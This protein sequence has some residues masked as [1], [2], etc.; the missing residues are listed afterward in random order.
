MKFLADIQTSILFVRALRLLGWDIARA[1]DHNQDAKA[2]ESVLHVATSL[3]RVLIT[4]DYFRP[5]TRVRVAT[6][7]R[8]YGGRVIRIGGGPDQATERAIGKLLFHHPDWH[9]WLE[10]NE[11]KV[12]IRDITQK[13]T[14]RSRSD[15]HAEIRHVDG[16]QFEPYLDHKKELRKR[17]L[18]RKP[19][20]R[21]I[22][23]E[24]KHLEDA[25]G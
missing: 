11:G 20:K 6:E 15:I 8:D 23:P 25:H 17:P 4:F 22:A 12:E 10:A 19:R 24:Q 13:L 18:N 2:D 16:D 5:P 7:L 14:L 3:N 21:K 9:P 1:Q